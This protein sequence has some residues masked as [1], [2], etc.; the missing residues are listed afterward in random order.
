MNTTAAAAEA[1][2]TVTTIR[3][4]CRNGAVAATKR[5]GRWVID[6]DSLTR[7]IAIGQRKARMTVTKYRIEERDIVQYGQECH[8]FVIVR[9]DG[10]PAG[11]GPGKDNRITG[12]PYFTRESAE[13]YMKFYE[14]TPPGY[15]LSRKSHSSR[16]VQSGYYWLLEGGGQDD[17]SDIRHT[18]DDGREVQGNWPEGTTWLDVLISLANR[19]AAGAPERIRK[20]AEKDAVA[21]AEA[22]VREVREQ[23]LNTAQAE[24]GE[25]ATERQVDYIVQ[26]LAARARSGEGGGFMTGPTGRADIELMSKAEASLYITSLKGDY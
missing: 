7:R 13:R 6:N 23:Q 22:A 3:T 11:Y 2:V 12:D 10:T 18:W 16:S 8:V 21:E 1:N 25:L 5:A 4:W 17:P 20:K 14:S 9:T 24:K 19:H 26:L 15:R